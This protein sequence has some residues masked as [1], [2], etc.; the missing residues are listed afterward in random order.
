VSVLAHERF[1]EQAARTP[2]SVA[3][4]CGAETVTYRE[5]N[6]RANRIAH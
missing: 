2:D 3:V 6:A 1:E 4:R 5:L